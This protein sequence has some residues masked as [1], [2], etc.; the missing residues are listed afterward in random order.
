[1]Q[2]HSTDELYVKVA[3]THGSD[4]ALSNDS[5]GLRQQRVK[6]LAVLVP[7]FEFLGFCPQRVIVKHLCALLKRIYGANSFLN[8]T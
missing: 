8:S 6:R 3:H 5:K 2:Y 4:T 7:H 1:V